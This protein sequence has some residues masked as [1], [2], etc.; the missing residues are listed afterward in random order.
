LTTAAPHAMN[1][2]SLEPELPALRQRLLRQARL[3]VH[4]SAH[5]EDLVQDTLMAVVQQGSTYRGDAALS[6]WAISILRH[7]VADWYRS[8]TARREVQMPEGEEGDAID[9]ALADQ[10]DE[11]GHWREAV[12][13]WQQPEQVSERKQMMQT[14]DGCLSCLPAQTRRVF[15]M[16]E[17]LGFE[18]DEIREQLGLSADNVRTVLH[19]A[20]MSLRACMQQRWFGGAAGRP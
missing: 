11:S 1:A 9:A 10:F 16:R 4:D 18:S 12:P 17:W 19:R 5:A 8:P 15:M 13:E 14:F 6:T 7:K 20:R 2:K 3:A